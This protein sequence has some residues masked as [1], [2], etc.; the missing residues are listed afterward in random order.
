MYINISD[1]RWR[2]LRRLNRLYINYLHKRGVKIYVD[3][4]CP[5]CGNNIGA[6]TPDD[7]VNTVITCGGCKLNLRV[8]I[9]VRPEGVVVMPGLTP[10]GASNN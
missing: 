2:I 5:V 8:R 9:S 7:W 4:L 10:G 1:I 3:W 6:V